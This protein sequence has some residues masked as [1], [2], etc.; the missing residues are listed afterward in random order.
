ME[1]RIIHEVSLILFTSSVAVAVLNLYAAGAGITLWKYM[2]KSAIPFSILALSA[3]WYSF[4]EGL[5]MAGLIDKG[6]PLFTM[7]LVGTGFAM[8]SI[9][10]LTLSVH[11]P[12]R[13]PRSRHFLY[14]LG[15]LFGPLTYT[16][17]MIRPES[18]RVGWE[19]VHKQ[20]TVL[21]VLHDPAVWTFLAYTGVHVVFLLASIIRVNRILIDTGSSREQKISSLL[22][23]IA[24]AS[25]MGALVF[26]NFKNLLP[27]GVPYAEL[28]PLLTFPPVLIFLYTVLRMKKQF[29]KLRED[30]LRGKII[31]EELET[32]RNLQQRILP[33]RALETSRFR[34]TPLYLPMGKVGGD[35]LDYY[36]TG[37]G[38]VDFFV[39][40]V[41]GHGV[42]AAFHA[43]VTRCIIRTA[44]ERLSIGERLEFLN[45]QLFDYT[46]GNGFVTIFYASLDIHSMEMRYASAGHHPSL[47][48]RRGK[49]QC[50]R[51]TGRGRL[52]GCV[53]DVNIEEKGISLE[54]GDRFILFTDGLLEARDRVGEE[55][56][57]QRLNS[58]IQQN[59][60]LPADQL[61]QGLLDD[62]VRYTGKDEFEDDLTLLVLDVK[63]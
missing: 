13:W 11:R 31:E 23:L 19:L 27:S 56:G 20:V 16:L 61:L 9:Y 48:Y 46:K 10:L 21:Q 58:F 5:Q 41:A 8:P 18:Y 40:D 47:L 22:I 37:D 7:V 25:G 33:S 60:H 57:E 6:S 32:T 14:L 36:H 44:S 50:E 59:L 53:E 15:G 49:D 34:L 1:Y 38:Q 54:A 42:P 3:G 30:R 63:K 26:T 28:G 4:W 45:S 55:Y 39:F 52:L 35:L 43:L 62:I 29:D 51:L 2:G 17:A 12:G 24:L